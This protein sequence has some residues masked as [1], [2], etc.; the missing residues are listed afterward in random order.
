MDKSNADGVLYKCT[1]LSFIIDYLRWFE[2]EIENNEFSILN[3]T[4]TIIKLF[5][6]LR[7]TIFIHLWKFLFQNS[8]GFV[9]A[10]LASIIV[11]SFL[12]VWF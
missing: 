11:V 2:E 8:T 4:I 6:Q 3:D 1:V 5:K 12:K 7:N 10:H 9:D